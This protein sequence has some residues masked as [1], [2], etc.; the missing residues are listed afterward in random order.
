MIEPPPAR[1][2]AGIWC[3]Q[4]RKTP[5]TVDDPD[6]HGG[7]VPAEVPLH[8]VAGE[9]D[10]EG[11]VAAGD[12]RGPGPA[13][14]LED[15]AVDGD[16]ALAELREVDDPAER[17][18]DEPLDLVGPAADAADRC[19]ARGSGRRWR[20]AA[21]C[22][23]RSPSRCPCRGGAAGRGPRWSPRRAHGSRRG[24]SGRSPRPTSG[25]RARPRPAGARPAAVRHRGARARSRSTSS[26]PWRPGGRG[27]SPGR[28]RRRPRRPSPHP[29]AR[30]AARTIDRGARRLVRRRLAP[31]A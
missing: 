26:L 30:R 19:L 27:P 21:C 22:T 14:G 8:P 17:P 13:V 6:A 31:R 7:D 12:R 20:A 11:D 23:R 25:G 18:P 15:V 2:I 4:P 3:L 1:R 9:R 24:G 10:R 29:T 28:P 16:G 5:L